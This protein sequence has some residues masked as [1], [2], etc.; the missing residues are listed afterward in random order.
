MVGWAADGQAWVHRVGADGS[1][2]S[3][4]IEVEDNDDVTVRTS[5]PGTVSIAYNP[6]GAQ[7]VLVWHGRRSLAAPLGVPV[8]GFHDQVYGQRLGLDGA[9]LGDDIQVSEQDE[10]LGDSRV[11]GATVAANTTN[12]EF[13]VT[14][15][16]E[17]TA[18][19]D[20]EDFEVIGQRL[21][22]D[23]SHLGDPFAVT[24]G[25]VPFKADLAYNPNANQFV[26]TF[27]ALPLEDED[28]R[29][30]GPPIAN[31][32]YAQVLA[33]DGSQAEG[34]FQVS[35]MHSGDP[36]DESSGQRPAVT[37]D[38]TTCDYA[39]VWFGTRY[40][41]EVDEDR[42]DQVWGRRI[43]APA[44]PSPPPAPAVITPVQ[45]VS[46]PARPAR[47][48]VSVAGV[49][50]SCIRRT[51]RVRVR[52]ALASGVR[53]TSARVTLN[54]KRIMTSRRTRFSVSVNPKR[55][56]AGR[57]YRLRIVANDSAGNRRTINRTIRVCAAQRERRA[58]PRFTG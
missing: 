22:S 31:E 33:A 54:G 6:V 35:E 32:V 30:G 17:Q 58:T 47:P 56:R 14:W 23:G 4:D 55:L 16:G 1:D 29:F 36:E 25:M 13:L 15:R 27:N 20:D 19:Q 44:C 37:Y 9:E 3:D 26:A 18:G 52:I 53:L 39:S 41:S 46:A 28:L 45:P 42:T 10:S 43:A 12:G 40:S 34:R 49:R 48:R 21:G 2:K 57:R 7:Y 51:T 38:P 24:E 5:E 50:S 8:P 11:A